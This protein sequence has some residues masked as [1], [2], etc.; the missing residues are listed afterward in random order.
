MRSDVEGFEMETVSHGG[1]AGEW[2]PMAR[3]WR[4]ST[5]HGIL[6]AAGQK[7]PVLGERHAPHAA[8]V[9]L[10]FRNR[11]PAIRAKSGVWSGRSPRD[12]L[13]GP[14]SR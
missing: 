13:C 5:P 4:G 1:I 9:T 8:G 2:V 14:R 10:Q 7:T 3:G 11:A 12:E 6:A